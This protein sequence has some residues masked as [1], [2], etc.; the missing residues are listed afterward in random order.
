[1]RDGGLMAQLSAGTLTSISFY[2]NVFYKS[3]CKHP[4]TEQGHLLWLLE[5]TL[6]AFQSPHIFLALFHLLYLPNL[7][8]ILGLPDHHSWR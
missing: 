6:C 5:E 3:L 2:P 7:R 4:G 1:M 8:N